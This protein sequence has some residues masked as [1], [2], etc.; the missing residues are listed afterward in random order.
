M[1]ICCATLI[2][3]YN[4][5]HTFKVVTCKFFNYILFIQQVVDDKFHDRLS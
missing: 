2:V 4:L 5:M 3:R 1:N